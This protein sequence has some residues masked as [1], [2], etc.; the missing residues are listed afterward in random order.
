MDKPK[1]PNLT[2]AYLYGLYEYVCDP[3]RVAAHHAA[4]EVY[5]A[6]LEADL[7]ELRADAERYRWLRENCQDA[8]D[9]WGVAA[10]LYFGTY[11]SGNLDA[12]IDAARQSESVND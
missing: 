3:K 5:V 9:E 11:A 1:M 12:A 4:W 7:A 10:Q 8:P 6:A 2:E